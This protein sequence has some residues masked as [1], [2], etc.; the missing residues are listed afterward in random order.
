MIGI[1][2]DDVQ[3]IGTVDE[4]YEQILNVML[5][6]ELPA[7]IAYFIVGSIF[8]RL[9]REIQRPVEQVFLDL[10]STFKNLPSIEDKIHELPQ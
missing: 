9:S 1:N 8:A 3:I 4:L 7:D 10:S 2:M 5:S 6:K